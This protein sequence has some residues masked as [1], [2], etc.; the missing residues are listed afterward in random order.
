MCGIAGVVT[1]DAPLDNPEQM[2]RA[3]DAALSHRGPDGSGRLVSPRGDALLVHRRLAIIVPS[4]A[5]AQPMS[6]PD[7]R[8]TLIFN[9]EIYNYRELRASAPGPLRT[10]SDTEVVLQLVAAHGPDA[11]PQLRGMFAFA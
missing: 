10:A 5:A 3:L 11:L 4:A 9:G 8:Y 1:Y 2:A 6:S 7:G